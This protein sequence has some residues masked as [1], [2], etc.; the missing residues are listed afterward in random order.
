MSSYWDCRSCQHLPLS[1]SITPA[2]ESMTTCQKPGEKGEKNKSDK[3]L[4]TRAV[5]EHL[6]PGPVISTYLRSTGQYSTECCAQIRMM[7]SDG[8][9]INEK[10]SQALPAPTTGRGE[11][12]FPQLCTIKIPLD[13]NIPLL[14][15]VCLS[16]GP[17]PHL[18]LKTTTKR[19]TFQ[20]SRAALLAAKGNPAAQETLEGLR[21]DFSADC[22]I[23]GKGGFPGRDFI[24]IF[25]GQIRHWGR[26]FTSGFCERR[27]D[28]QVNCAHKG[29]DTRDQSVLT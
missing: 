3:G 15:P 14:R 28:S 6:L 25:Q 10:P 8:G 23:H 13:F 22:L 21:G 20:Q 12:L 4:A 2:S 29:A 18:H 16:S 24:T 19:G 27:K 26:A 9:R 5:Q 7:E 11:F 17:K 1:D